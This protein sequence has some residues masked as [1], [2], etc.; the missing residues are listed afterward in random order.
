MSDELSQALKREQKVL[1]FVLIFFE[2][3]YLVRFTGYALI[4]HLDVVDSDVYL[5]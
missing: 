4:L 1:A 3:S 5:T 2:I